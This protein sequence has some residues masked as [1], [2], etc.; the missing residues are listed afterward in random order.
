MYFALSKNGSRVFATRP[1]TSGPVVSV[2]SVAALSVV[3][4][5]EA[6]PSLAPLCRASPS[7]DGLTGSDEGVPGSAA[8]VTTGGTIPTGPAAAKPTTGR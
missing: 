3:T 5:S 7:K 2:V 1:V 4:A 8:D 6:A